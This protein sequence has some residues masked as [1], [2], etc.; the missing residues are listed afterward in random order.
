MK[1]QVK[2]FGQ[3][4]NEE[5]GHRERGMDLGMDR[6]S[7]IDSM[8]GIQE[9]AIFYVEGMRSAGTLTFASSGDSMKVDFPREDA[10][11]WESSDWHRHVC[12]IAQENGADAVYFPEDGVIV[13]C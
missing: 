5:F 10:E 6:G 11:N 7:S 9:L 3:F 1:A 12:G 4:V 2:K 8:E 13:K